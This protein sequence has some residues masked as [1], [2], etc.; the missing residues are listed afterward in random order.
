MN[1]RRAE[2]SC[3]ERMSMHLFNPPYMMNISHKVRRSPFGIATASTK[4]P[5]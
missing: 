3:F 5:G 4:K 2:Q 1:Q